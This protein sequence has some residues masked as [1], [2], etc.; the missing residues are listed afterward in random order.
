MRAGAGRICRI[1]ALLAAVLVAGPLPVEGKGGE[2]EKPPEPKELKFPPG[3]VRLVEG[4]RGALS[5]DGKRL[6]FTRE[7]KTSLETFVK[8]TKGKK[9][10]KLPQASA[11]VGWT[12]GGTL[13]LALGA[14]VEPVKGARVRTVAEVPAEK[15]TWALAW[16]RDG[17]RLAY[18]P[19]T[20]GATTTAVQWLAVGSVAARLASTDGIRTDQLAQLAWSPDGAR[21][22]VNALFQHGTEKP[23]RKIGVV[24]VAA[25][26]LKVVAEMPDWSDLPGL[27]AR[28]RIY[29]DPRA[30]GKDPTMQV[31]Y[32]RPDGPRHGPDVWGATGTHFTWLAGHGWT[33]A[34]AF[35]ADAA[36][37]E[38]WRLTNDGEAKWSP[39]LDPAGKRLAFLSA[40]DGGNGGTYKNAIVRVVDLRAEALVDLPIPQNSIPQNSVPPSSTLQGGVPQ[41]RGVPGRLAWTAEGKE[42]VYEIVGGPYEGV[43]LQTVPPGKAAEANAPIRRVDIVATDRVR[44][45]L[46]SYDADRVHAG[47]HRAEDAWDPVY[48]GALRETLTAWALRD[49]DKGLTGCLI[50]VLEHHDAKESIPELRAALASPRTAVIYAAARA[51]RQFKDPEAPALLKKALAAAKADDTK[52]AL[53]AAIALAGDDAGW[54]ALADQLKHGEAPT[55]MKVCVELAK[56]R[57]ARAVDVLIPLLKDTSV[58]PQ[59]R[60]EPK[61]VRDAA[62]RAL[63]ELTS[64]NLGLDADAWAKWWESDAKKVLPPVAK[65]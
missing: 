42:V 5:P 34:D 60:V 28:R 54:E 58:D 27:H 35:V 56:V 29:R 18:V 43:Y 3:C 62:L 51:L 21:L 7:T 40:D 11:P 36:G 37:G 10:W 47:V 57:L 38:T 4:R 23:W 61:S 39:A 55:R 31:T 52:A 65:K 30:E 17:A 46:A 26:T 1:A 8:E 16:T 49:V 45:W 33:E 12:D 32:A 19:A 50:H 25:D 64:Q 14:G 2:K 59:A 20:D 53:A 48:V 13:L 15:A 44:A 63:R 9:E 6:A 22:F 24:D 41:E